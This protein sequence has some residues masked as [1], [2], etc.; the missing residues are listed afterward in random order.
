MKF[1]L[2]KFWL[3]LF[4]LRNDKTHES[5]DNAMSMRVSCSKFEWH[6][7]HVRIDK[8]KQL[9]KLVDARKQVFFY[10][11]K[12][13][14]SVVLRPLFIFL[15]IF[16][17]LHNSI[18]IAL[19]IHFKALHTKA[20]S[21]NPSHT[22]ILNKTICIFLFLRVSTCPHTIGVPLVGIQSVA[23]QLRQNAYSLQIANTQFEMRNLGFRPDFIIFFAITGWI[24]SQSSRSQF[25]NRS[26]DIQ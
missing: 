3:C 14:S 9:K 26:S 10:K 13:F 6:L 22:W 21:A 15:T 17:L 16:S 8:W 1:Q 20:L 18:W 5:R 24:P 25:S 7:L 11:K 4:C 23:Q 2:A 19:F 12:W